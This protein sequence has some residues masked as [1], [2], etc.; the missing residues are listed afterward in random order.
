[1]HLGLTALLK[2]YREHQADDALVLDNS[3]MTVEEQMVWFRERF[4]EI[5]SGS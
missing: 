5:M 4:D 3:E 2:F 1:M